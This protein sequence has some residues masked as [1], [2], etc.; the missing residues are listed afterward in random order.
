MRISIDSVV[1]VELMRGRSRENE[2]R[3]IEEEG[4]YLDFYKNLGMR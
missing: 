3:V 2:V 4:V 1:G